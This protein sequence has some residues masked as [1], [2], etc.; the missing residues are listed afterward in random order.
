MGPVWGFGG[1]EMGIALV[2]PGCWL[3]SHRA[4]IVLCLPSF[5]RLGVVFFALAGVGLF[6]FLGVG[7]VFGVFVHE[8]FVAGEV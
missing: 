7:F 1:R 6:G 3:P 5:M 2:G 8:R 4:R